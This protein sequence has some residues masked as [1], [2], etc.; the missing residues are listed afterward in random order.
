[1]ATT[2]GS[3][4]RRVVPAWT[5]KPGP[6]VSIA[7]PPG[8]VRAQAIAKSAAAAGLAAGRPGVTEQAIDLAVSAHLL[9]NEVEHVWT[10]TNVGLGKNA[11]IC[12]PTNPPT[13]LAAVTHRAWVAFARTGDPG[14]PAYR[15]PGGHVQSIGR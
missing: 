3:A 11:R 6:D 13:E 4:P 7:P 1:M 14:W 12:F 15:G 10:I 9:A 5:Y 2:M 8:L